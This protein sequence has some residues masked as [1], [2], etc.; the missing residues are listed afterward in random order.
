[1]PPLEGARLALGLVIPLMLA[2][3]FAG[4][5]GAWE[6]N[7]LEDSYARVASALWAYDGGLTQLLLTTAAWL[8]GCLGIHFVLRHRAA[9]RQRFHWAF[10][11]MLLVPSLALLG[12]VSMAREVPVRLAAR[13]LLPPDTLTAAAFERL[14]RLGDGLAAAFTALVV[15]TLLLRLARGVYE[16]RRVGQVVLGYPQRQVAVPRGWSVLEASRAHGIAHL[17]LCGGRARCSTCRIRV[18][19]DAAHLPPPS[20]A[21]ALTLRRIAAPPDVRLAC[22]LRPTGDITVAP[23]L[24]ARGG[25]QGHAGAE[26]Q[27]VVLFVDLRRWTTLSERHLPHDLAYVLDQFFEVV[28]EAVRA[29][30]GVPNQ[31]VGD[32]VMALFGLERDLGT[33]CTQAIRAAAAI[34]SGM[35]GYN[36]RLQ[37]EFGHTIDFGM[38]VHAGAAAVGEVGWRDTRTFSAVG[39]AVN[40]AARLQELSKAYGVRL[41]VSETVAR[42]AGLATEGLARN[43]VAVR[44]RSDALALYAIATAAEGADRLPAVKS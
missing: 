16:R 34:E 18:A 9:W 22:Q 1:M 39:D 6:L 41:V 3:H 19:G 17:S 33:A 36:E 2:A 25:D 42:M 20:D 14:V 27:V 15:V 31:F 26:R 30:G 21:E 37:Q 38:G 8:H 13:E 40:T 10:A 24:R 23:L 4:T 5:R 43:E 35:A 44:G 7:G 29:A 11:G 12:F 32:S 28:G